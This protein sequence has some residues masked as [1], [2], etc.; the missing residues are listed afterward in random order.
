LRLREVADLLGVSRK[1]LYR[2]LATQSGP[3]FKTT[4]GGTLLFQRRDVEQW[5][6][7]LSGS[8]PDEMPAERKSEAQ[9]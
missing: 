3:P 8:S 1:T 4:P 9:Q 2:W 6:A 5:Y 7:R